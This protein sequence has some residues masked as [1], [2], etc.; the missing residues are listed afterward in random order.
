MLIFV[1]HKELFSSE[2]GWWVDGWCESDDKIEITPLFPLQTMTVFKDFLESSTIHVLGNISTFPSN[3][4]KLFS[5]A[6]V[7]AG[8]L[9]ATLQIRSAF[10]DWED[11][12][13]V[14]SIATF[15]V[16]NLTFPRKS[17]K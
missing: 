3:L 6:V 12:P 16:E 5:A 7:I 14:T 1:Y 10:L 11:N 17:S 2:F 8:F 13:T 15:P 9:A 4:I